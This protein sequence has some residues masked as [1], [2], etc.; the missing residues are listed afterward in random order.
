[1]VEF[2]A[3]RTM[4]TVLGLALPGVWWSRSGSDPE[5]RLVRV[6]HV[7]GET[8]G[9]DVTWRIEPTGDGATCRVTISHDFSPGMPGF[10]WFVDRFFT[11][12]IARRTLSTF[13]ALAEAVQS[14]APPP[15]NL[16][17]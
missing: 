3:R 15:T 2:I 12:P 5:T 4:A 6:E 14:A 13:K 11:R 7:G 16:S 9:M 1:M 8:R 17:P 10:A